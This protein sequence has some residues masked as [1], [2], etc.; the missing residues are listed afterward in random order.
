MDEPS[1][2]SGGTRRKRRKRRRKKLPKGTSS[3]FLCSGAVDQGIMFGYVDELSIEYVQRA[4][5]LSS[6]H[7]KEVTGY[8]GRADTTPGMNEMGKFNKEKV[9]REREL[10]HKHGQA[11][12]E[13]V[14]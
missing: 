13:L 7:C 5:V 2:S 14:Q 3:S 1:S 9:I 10:I 11:G 4:D 6:V 8:S 12:V